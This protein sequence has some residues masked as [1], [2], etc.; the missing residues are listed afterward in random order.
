MLATTARALLLTLL[1]LPAVGL[2][3]TWDLRSYTGTMLAL[4][5]GRVWAYGYRY[6]E[7]FLA[8]VAL[9]VRAEQLTDALGQWTAQL[10]LPPAAEEAAPLVTYYIDGHRKPVYTEAHP[11]WI[12]WT[13]WRDPRLSGVSVAP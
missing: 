9:S 10:W 11:T 8:E 1:F 3:R 4:L 6:V 7:R 12:D 2:K 13:H 5:T